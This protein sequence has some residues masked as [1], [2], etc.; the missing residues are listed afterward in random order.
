MNR[1]YCK[2]CGCKIDKWLRSDAIYCT[3]YCQERERNIKRGR[4][5]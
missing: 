3:D 1:Y 2:R 4:I 5:K